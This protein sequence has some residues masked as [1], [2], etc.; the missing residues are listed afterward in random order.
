MHNK[1]QS[2][3]R[4]G[5]AL[6]QNELEQQRPEKTKPKDKKEQKFF[7]KLQQRQRLNENKIKS[8]KYT[9]GK[10]KNYLELQSEIDQLDKDKVNFDNLKMDDYKQTPD[11]YYSEG[12]GLF[13]KACCI[14]KMIFLYKNSD[15]LEECLE[16]YNSETYLNLIFDFII[17]RCVKFACLQ[18]KF[19]IEQTQKLNPDKTEF[20]YDLTN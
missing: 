3:K 17:P 8:N 1:D 18:R 13:M 20:K 19:C 11:E 16:K 2:K 9:V 14:R 7:D 6:N 12:F 4:P 5:Q 15:E 10:I